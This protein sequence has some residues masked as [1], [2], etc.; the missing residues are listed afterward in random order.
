MKQNNLIYEDD[1]Q[2]K[3]GDN[4]IYQKSFRHMFCVL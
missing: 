2:R 1:I 4:E 3:D